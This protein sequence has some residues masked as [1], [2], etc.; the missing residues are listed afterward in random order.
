MNSTMIGAPEVPFLE[1]K[2]RRAPPQTKQRRSGT[3]TGLQAKE[4]RACKTSVQ[5]FARRGHIKVA[6]GLAQAGKLL[7]SVPIQQT[8]ELC[9]GKEFVGAAVSCEVA[10]KAAFSSRETYEVNRFAV[11]RINVP[12]ILHGRIAC[13][14]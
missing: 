8:I 5:Q 4:A 1:R 14:A 3:R 7:K 11:A 10:S 12:V 2:N 6:V 13:Q 9:L